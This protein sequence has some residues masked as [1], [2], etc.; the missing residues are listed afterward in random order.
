MKIGDARKGAAHFSR[1][2]KTMAAVY[3]RVAGD[4]NW[5]K[6]VDNIWPTDAPQPVMIYVNGKR[7]DLGDRHE[8]A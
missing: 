1:H 5:T 7:L 2:H 3:E 6:V 4:Y 8:A